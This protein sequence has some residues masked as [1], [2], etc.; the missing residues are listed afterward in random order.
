[1]RH[2]GSTREELVE[3]V[4]EGVLAAVAELLGVPPSGVTATRVLGSARRLTG[5]AELRFEV[6]AVGAA[7]GPRG[8]G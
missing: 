4:R 3:D 8:E 5:G 7:R 1:M 6:A 2:S